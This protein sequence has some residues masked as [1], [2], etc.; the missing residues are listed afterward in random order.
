MK[1]ST[2]E[3]ISMPFEEPLYETV[4]EL[5][6]KLLLPQMRL[7]RFMMI[8]QNSLLFGIILENGFVSQ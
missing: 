2:R 8:W 1:L 5:S 4:S 7:R 6:L 3:F